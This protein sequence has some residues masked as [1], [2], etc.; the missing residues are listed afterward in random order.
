M[1][2]L[3]PRPTARSTDRRSL[4]KAALATAAVGAMAMPGPARIARAQEG[5]VSTYAFK[6]AIQTLD[7]MLTLGTQQLANGEMIIGSEVELVG[8]DKSVNA[9]MIEHYL[10]FMQELVP[11]LA[12]ARVA[13][14]WGCLRPMSIDLLPI[15]GPAPGVGGLHLITGH[16]RS[17]MGLAPASAK[18]LVDTLLTGSADLD[19][20]PYSPARFA[21]I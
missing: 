11:A 10:R 17:G 5:R 1:A 15:I 2:V 16:G 13:R 19:L 6:S 18:A 14:S 12:G 3:T 4:L 21:N 9:G 8:Y 20:V 7:P